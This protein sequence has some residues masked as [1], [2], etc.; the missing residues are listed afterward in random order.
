M[1][2]LQREAAEQ[3]TECFHVDMPDCLLCALFDCHCVCYQ[4]FVDVLDALAFYQESGG[5]THR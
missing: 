1:Q 3:L 5:P 4:V 2:A